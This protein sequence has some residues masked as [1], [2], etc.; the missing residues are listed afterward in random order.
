MNWWKKLK[1]RLRCF[2]S[3]RAYDHL[4]SVGYNCEI[5]FQFFHL[6]RFLE[7][8]LFAWTYAYSLQD[9]IHAIQHLEQVGANGFLPPDPL[10]QCRN[11]NV[12]FHLKDDPAMSLPQL[13]KELTSR[14]TYLKNKWVKVCADTNQSVLYIVKV[15]STDTQKNIDLLPQLY[16]TLKQTTQAPFDLLIVCE[17]NAVLPDLNN[18]HIFIRRVDHYAPDDDVPNKKLAA[19]KDWEQIFFEFGPKHYLEHMKHFKFEKL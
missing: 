14:V 6:Y 5:A 11:T 7:S 9:T 16:S 18:P 4:V 13:E 1:I 19:M 12:R 2:R 10:C 8:S 17:K 15:R 3:Q